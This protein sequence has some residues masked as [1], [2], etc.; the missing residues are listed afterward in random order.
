MR[1]GVIERSAA[2]RALRTITEAVRKKTIVFEGAVRH[3]PT[4]LDFSEASAWEK[5]AGLRLNTYQNGAYWHT[6]TGWLIAAVR[7]RDPPLAAELFGDYIQHLRK[8]DFRLNH[9]PEAPW[10]CFGP[11]HYAQNGV[12]MTSVTVPVAVMAGESPGLG[13]H[14]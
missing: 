12:Y 1:L 11:S 9:G 3:V 14:P 13:R 7:R 4:D 6:P 2:E 8:N 10:E 5:T